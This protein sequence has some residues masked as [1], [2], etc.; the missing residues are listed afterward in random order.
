ML[1]RIAEAVDALTRIEFNDAHLLLAIAYA[2]LGRL[3]D[4]RTEVEKMVKIN[5]NITV[6]IWRQGYSFW[7]AAIPQRYT[8]DL[9]QAGLPA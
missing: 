6:Q 5:P 3:G 1:G 2:R 9:A 8:I 4:A 7:D